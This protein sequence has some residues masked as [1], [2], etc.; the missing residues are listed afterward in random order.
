MVAYVNSER[1]PDEAVVLVSGHAYPAW[2]YYAPDIEPLRLP[3]I[4]TLDVNAVLGLDA[5]ATLDTGLAGRRGAWLVQWQ[6]EAGGS[7]R[8][9]ALSA[10]HRGRRPA[11]FG[12]LLGLGAPLR[13]RFF[14]AVRAGPGAQGI[15]FPASRR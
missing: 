3:E 7:Q 2:R 11:C 10:G 1:Q 13:Y 15:A 4:E 12:Q 9:R 8:R 14:D 5:A 6:N